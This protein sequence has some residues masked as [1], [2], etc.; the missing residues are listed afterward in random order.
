[1]V[2]GI[3]LW[4]V[5]SPHLRL[6]FFFDEAWRA[7]LIRSA[8][9]LARYRTNNAPIPPLWIAV[10]RTTSIVAPD[11]FAGLRL[12]NLALAVTFPVSA[13]ILF[14]VLLGRQDPLRAVPVSAAVT[15][16]CSVVLA[17]A[18]VATYLNDYSFQAT[19]VVLVVLLS[20]L[21]DRG[22]IRRGWAAAG[23][24]LL[25]TA[26]LGGL[27]VLPVLFLWWLR[28][29]GWP[30]DAT[31]WARRAIV[32]AVSCAVALTMYLWLYRPQVDAGLKGFWG[33]EILHDGTRSVGTVLVDIPRSVAVRFFP[34]RF[35]W[36]GNAGVGLLVMLLALAGLPTLAR[37]WRW[38][39]WIIVTS[40]PIA[41]VLSVAVAWPVTFTRVNLPFVWLWYGSAIVGVGAL[42]APLLRRRAAPVYAAC[43]LLALVLVPSRLP[44]S[45]AGYARGLYRDLDVIAASPY[46]HNVALSYHFMSHFYVDD[47]LEN[48]S[49]HPDRFTV[50][51]EVNGSDELYNE[52]DQAILDAGWQRGDA[53]WCVIPYEVGPDTA[54]R[55]CH[56]TLPGLTQRY[57][58][59][60]GRA[61]I[62][63]WFPAPPRASTNSSVTRA[64]SALRLL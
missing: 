34:P 14:G 40:W 42:L 59:R 1:M 32:P 26:T 51:R 55:A 28:P 10:L 56:V 35:D 4:R 18:G 47:K 33:P 29:N 6:E 16:V 24:V 20:L 37:A 3:I 31:T 7:D 39:P 62:I 52:T 9:P 5:A 23:I 15:V 61:W 22:V 64:A 21:V 36:L 19:A 30:V 25:P 44:P 43:A 63:G 46:A 12:Q 57:S 49:S 53:V 2:S 48:L 45:N 13:G 58:E 60:L 50:V 27:V 8:H 17:V 54:D 38:M 41:A 11:G